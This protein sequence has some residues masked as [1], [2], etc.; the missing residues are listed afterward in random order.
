MT[1]MEV[2]NELVEL[3]VGVTVHHVWSLLISHGVFELILNSMEVEV[4]ETI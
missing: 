1:E 3:S 2:T 4:G